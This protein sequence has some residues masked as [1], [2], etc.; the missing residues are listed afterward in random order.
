MPH[1]DSGV[2]TYV[3][4]KFKYSLQNEMLNKDIIQY[5]DIIQCVSMKKFCNF[6]IYRVRSKKK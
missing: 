3:G 6:T 4:D 1:N 5:K 2:G